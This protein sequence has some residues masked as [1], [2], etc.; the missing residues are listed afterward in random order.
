M[1]VGIYVFP[2]HCPQRTYANGTVED[3]KS[4]VLTDIN[5]SDATRP[6]EWNLYS[7][8]AVIVKDICRFYF[9]AEAQKCVLENDFL[10]LDAKAGDNLG[11]HF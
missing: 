11:L 8:Q 9:A 10:K 3:G 7:D 5:M 1:T 2:D 4:Y 6:V